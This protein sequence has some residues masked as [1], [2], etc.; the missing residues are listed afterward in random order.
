MHVDSAKRMLNDNFELILVGVLTLGT[1]YTVLVS[2]NKLAFLN[3]F[4]IP[5]L[6]AAFFLGRR[7]GVLASVVAVLMIA[8]FAVINPQLFAYNALE[9]P[10]LNVF[11]WGSFLIV[12]AFVVGTLY[13]HKTRATG[14]LKQAYEGILEIV[15]KF[16][17]TVDGYTQEHSVRVSR[18]ARKIAEEMKLDVESCENVRVAGLLHDVGKLDINLE[19]LNKA[20]ALSPTEWKHMMT[21]TSKGTALIQPMG[22]LLR[23][24]L[25][26][27]QYH[28]EFFDGSGYYGAGDEEIPLGARILAVADSYDAMITDRPYR[29][30]RTPREAKNEIQLRARQQY[31]PRVVEAFLV[32]MRNEVQLD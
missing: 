25:P 13:D 15:A 7:R 16:I 8:V 20:S 31:D 9:T 12:T 32:V 22:G 4:Y 5:V 21:H 10:A 26:I 6:L 18:L 14:D 1:A 2:S 24:V 23:D 11:L 17:D 19:V 3:F 29:T 27:V 30:G 28:H